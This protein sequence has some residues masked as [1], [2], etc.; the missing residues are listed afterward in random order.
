M[1]TTPSVDDL[2]QLG[3]KLYMTDL[4]SVRDGRIADHSAAGLGAGAAC[5]KAAGAGAATRQARRANQTAL[6]SVYQVFG[7]PSSIRETFMGGGPTA[8]FLED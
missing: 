2:A 7:P 1:T 6:A 3:F 4:T 8:C 5:Q